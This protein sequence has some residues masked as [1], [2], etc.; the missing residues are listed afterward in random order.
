MVSTCTICFMNL[1]T[2]VFRISASKRDIFRAMNWMS[3]ICEV[4]LK[5]DFEFVGSM[6]PTLCTLPN[7]FNDI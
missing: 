3:D 5:I 1:E 2:E 6:I 4:T 7:H